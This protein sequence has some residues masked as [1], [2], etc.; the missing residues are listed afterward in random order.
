MTQD[1]RLI[2]QIQ[3]VSQMSAASHTGQL[4]AK[5]A[6]TLSGLEHINSAQEGGLSNIQRSPGPS[7]PVCHLATFEF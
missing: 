2:S 7:V 5:S 6:L 3:H 1:P 4:H